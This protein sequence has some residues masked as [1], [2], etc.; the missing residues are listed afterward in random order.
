MPDDD[1]NAPVSADCLVFERHSALRN[2]GIFMLI[3]AV[4]VPVFFIPGQREQAL[5]FLAANPF[6]AGFS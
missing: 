4:L 3:L 2:V 5:R 6:L 1:L